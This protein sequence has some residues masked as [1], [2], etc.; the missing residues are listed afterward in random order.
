MDATVVSAAPGLIQ[1]AHVDWDEP[2]MQALIHLGFRE[3]AT[4]TERFEAS[5]QAIV[6]TSKFFENG[7]DF[8]VSTHVPG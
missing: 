8:A 5:V 6:R 4:Q 7:W 1:S 2:T 3:G